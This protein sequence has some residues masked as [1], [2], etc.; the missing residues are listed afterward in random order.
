MTYEELEKK[1]KALKRENNKLKKEV[2]E[3][4]KSLQSGG[5]PKKL[6]KDQVENII[7][8]ERNYRAIAKEYNISIGTISTI[9]NGEYKF[10]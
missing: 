8:D 9:K 10:K 7:A 5:R 4:R 2:R 3:L 6:N 1:F